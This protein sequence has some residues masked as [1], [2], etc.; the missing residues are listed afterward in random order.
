M[1]SENVAVISAESNGPG[2]RETIVQNALAEAARLTKA[3]GYRYFV[4][5]SADDLSRRMTLE[6]SGPVFFAPS[7][8][9]RRSAGSPYGF[10]RDEYMGPGR[11]EER[12]W[13][14]LAITVRMYREG[15][16]EPSMGEVW[17]AT[18]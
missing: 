14:A 2:D 11:T 17:D 9:W 16:I 6:D 10:V 12:V 7:P 4:V 18:E 15:E 3:H 8:S 5:L 13:P 1:L